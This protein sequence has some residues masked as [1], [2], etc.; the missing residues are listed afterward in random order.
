MPF[1]ILGVRGLPTLVHDREGRPTRASRHKKRRARFSALTLPLST[2]GA[3][4]LVRQTSNMAS[5][6]CPWHLVLSTMTL[7]DSPALQRGEIFEI[8]VIAMQ[9]HG[10]SCP[11]DATSCE[12]RNVQRCRM[13][14]EGIATEHLRH[15]LRRLAS[16]TITHYR[17]EQQGRIT[18]YRSSSVLWGAP[19]MR[20]WGCKPLG[21]DVGLI[22]SGGARRSKT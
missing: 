13:S 7:N 14:E 2:S 1:A 17:E 15:L 5:A 4:S 10:Y 18:A 9:F 6:W 19:L 8:N 16:R 22:G 21:E 3:V 12:H 11:C 20:Q